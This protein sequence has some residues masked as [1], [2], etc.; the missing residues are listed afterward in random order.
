MSTEIEVTEVLRS[1]F[2][3]AGN[4]L[5]EVPELVGATTSGLPD[6][7]SGFFITLEDD[8]TYVVNVTQIKEGQ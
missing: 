1:L 7:E 8:T 5:T 4:D 3:Q 6:S 2:D